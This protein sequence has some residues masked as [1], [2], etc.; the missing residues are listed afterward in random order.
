MAGISVLADDVRQ[1]ADALDGVDAEF[2]AAARA[3]RDLMPEDAGPP[4]V[5]TALVEVVA[6]LQRRLGALAVE[7]GDGG[8]AVRRH[9]D[10]IAPPPG[11]PA[12]EDEP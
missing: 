10:D 2:S 5:S 7:A 11:T 9:L 12:T 1:L 8:R 3:L 6:R 4:D